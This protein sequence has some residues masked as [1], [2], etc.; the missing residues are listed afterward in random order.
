MWL[1]SSV[2]LVFEAEDGDL[3]LSSLRGPGPPLADQVGLTWRQG[4]SLTRHA[5]GHGWL[6]LAYPA[7]LSFYS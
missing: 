2:S 7:L 4:T 1:P 6:A 5:I 3:V